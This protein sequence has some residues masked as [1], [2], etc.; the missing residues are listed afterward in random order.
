MWNQGHNRNPAVSDSHCI[1]LRKYCYTKKTHKIQLQLP[2]HTHTHTQRAGYT[3]NEYSETA[4]T[5]IEAHHKYLGNENHRSKF[6]V[7]TLI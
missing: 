4:T 5:E 2:N 3:Q 1:S 7:E 6:S